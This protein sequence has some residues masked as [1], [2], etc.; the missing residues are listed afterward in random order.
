M[1]GGG[2]AGQGQGRKGKENPARRSAAAE[3]DAAQPSEF[4]KEEKGKRH[5]N[6]ANGLKERGITQRQGDELQPLINPVG[7]AEKAQDPPGKAFPLRSS[8]GDAD[9]RQDDEGQ[10]VAE[11]D[12]IDLS[13]NEINHW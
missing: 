5:D 12:V 10:T 7:K 13:L 4:D 1:A 8:Q 3:P 9:G 2:A 11:G 6:K